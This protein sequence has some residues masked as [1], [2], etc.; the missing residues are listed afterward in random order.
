MILALIVIAI[1]SYLL[2]SLNFGIIISKSLN[3]DDVRS[4]GSGNAGSTNM[5]RNFG[6]KYAVMT[7]IGDMLKVA[8]AILIAY[9]VMKYLG[10]TSLSKESS[11]QILG[12][13]AKMFTKSFAGFFC[14][15]G[16]IFPCFFSFKGGKGVATAGG[17]VFMIDWRIAIILLAIFIITVAVTKY[18]SLGSIIMAVLYPVLIFV[19]YKS[20]PLTVIS[21]VF[22]IIVVVAH[23]DNI[24]KLINNTE[25][26]IGSKK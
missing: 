10:H 2:G 5:L 21:A 16:H 26:K 22:T 6:K 23:R 14:V 20:L 12:V 19:F 17:M 9:L 15:I 7:I 18:V 24:K 8:V 3:K 4:H 13:D 11:A 1:L 25:S